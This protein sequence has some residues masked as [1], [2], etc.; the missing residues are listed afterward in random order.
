MPTSSGSAVR[1]GAGDRQGV[2]RLDRREGEERQRVGGKWPA[3]R[4]NITL[5]G[6]ATANQRRGDRGLG[7]GNTRTS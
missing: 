4:W 1:S 6:I 2:P 3:S 7:D 5:R